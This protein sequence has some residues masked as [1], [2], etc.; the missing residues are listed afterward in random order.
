MDRLPYEGARWW[1]PRLSP[2]W[3]R[4][5]RPLRLIR[6]RRREG[7]Q[8]VT[9][10]GLE[11]L[12]SAVSQGQ[13]VLITPNHVGHADAFV[14]LAA[15]DQLGRP[16]YYMIAWQVLQLFHFVG[17]WVLQRHGCF[18]VD[19]EAHDVRAFRQGVGLLAN[20]PH[21]LVIFP[22][23]E[24]YHNCDRLAPFREGAAAIALA[25]AQ[26]ARRSVVCVPAAIRYHY[27]EDPTP[28]LNQQM[29][30]LE[31]HLLWRPRPEYPLAERLRS[32]AEALLGLREQ[33]YLGQVQSGNYASRI[34]VLMEAILEPLEKRHGLHAPLR[35]LSPGE[36]DR[37]RRGANIPERVSAVR[38]QVIQQLENLSAHDLCQQTARNELEDLCLVVQL[39]SYQHDFATEQLSVER[40][41]DIVDKFEEDILGAPTASVHGKRRATIRFG[42]PV[43]VQKE[44]SHR[45]AI[46]QL[47]QTLEQEVKALLRQLTTG[48][49][50]VM[51]KPGW[52]R[53]ETSPRC[54]RSE[55]ARRSLLR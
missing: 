13:G 9:I 8:E 27:V 33:Y 24:V 26:R 29:D 2:F 44:R 1:R 25:A 11:H 53:S 19:R 52:G 49:E 10:D 34:P 38:Y 4:V 28:Q 55:A 36:R 31:R 23:G 37:V 35:T 43:A 21:P 22:E 14:L 20:S 41:A 54:T 50:S 7:L 39:F 18:S 3:V 32:F 42:K 48:K 16:F 46:R 45:G 12:R 40:L 30:A 51:T 17:R 47:T 15:A 5:I 6:Q